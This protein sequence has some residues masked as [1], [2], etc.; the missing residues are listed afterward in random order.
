M[1]QKRQATDKRLHLFEGYHLHS[2][3]IHKEL[4]QAMCSASGDDH[5][6]LFGCE[7]RLVAIRAMEAFQDHLQPKGGPREKMHVAD[8]VGQLQLERQLLVESAGFPEGGGRHVV[9]VRLQKLRCLCQG[10]PDVQ[11]EV[12]LRLPEALQ[13]LLGV[14]RHVLFH[15]GMAPTLQK[16][17]VLQNLFGL[18][19]AVHNHASFSSE[20]VQGP[21]KRCFTLALRR[22]RSDLLLQPLHLRRICHGC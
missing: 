11:A 16:V 14:G 20:K 13:H 8:P 15:F 9:L 2:Q 19:V 18:V 4:R 21:L 10:P 22:R 6:T 7:L 1:M 3:R 17:P 5:A 12:A